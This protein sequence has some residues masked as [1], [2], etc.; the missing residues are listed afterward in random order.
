MVLESGCFLRHVT[1]LLHFRAQ[2]TTSEL[3]M[4][5]LNIAAMEEDCSWLHG[6]RVRTLV[7]QPRRV[8]EHT[9]AGSR[10]TGRGASRP[11]ELAHSPLLPIP[12][13]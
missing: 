13:D 5:S 11:D 1:V 7:I 3:P 12:Q 2:R 6:Y 8:D 9:R 10:V 4:T